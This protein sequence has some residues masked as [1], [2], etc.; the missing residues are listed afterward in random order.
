MAFRSF[1]FQEPGTLCVAYCSKYKAKFRAV[2]STVKS[3]ALEVFYVDYGNYEWLKPSSVYS[4]EHLVI[5]SFYCV[6]ESWSA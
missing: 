6:L 2:I 3:E 5:F 4:I 1:L